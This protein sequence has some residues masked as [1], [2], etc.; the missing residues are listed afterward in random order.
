MGK[1]AGAFETLRRHP[2][3]RTAAMDHRVRI[4]ADAS[5]RI[6]KA[7]TVRSS[8]DPSIDTAIAEALTGVQLAEPPPADMPAPIVLRVAARR[9]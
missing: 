2:R 7:R 1:L 6:I 8:G 4:W 5:G 3:T 9:P